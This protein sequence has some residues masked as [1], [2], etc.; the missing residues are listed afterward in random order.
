M[1]GKNTTVVSV[2]YEDN[3]LFSTDAFPVIPEVGE[4][5]SIRELDEHGNASSTKYIV[6]SREYVF[7]KNDS[8]TDRD[9]YVMIRVRKPSFVD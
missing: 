6:S 4:V 5:I 8:K 3:L 9:I 2:F 1:N 7:Q